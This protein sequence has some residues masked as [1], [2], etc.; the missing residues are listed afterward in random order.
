[1]KGHRIPAVEGN[2]DIGVELIMPL[3]LRTEQPNDLG[4]TPR[5]DFELVRVVVESQISSLNQRDEKRGYRWSEVFI[6]TV[7][8]A[9]KCELQ[10]PEES[11][12]VFWW[13]LVN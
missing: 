2:D 4:V 5:N 3:A 9:G 6:H 8:T 11:R 10:P 12:L 7:T 13:W 1:M